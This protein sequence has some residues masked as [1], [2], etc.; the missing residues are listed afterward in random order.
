MRLAHRQADGVAR[1]CEILSAIEEEVEPALEDVEI[2]V[3]VRMDVRRHEGADRER[4]VPGKA[5]LRS[6]L[7]HIDL[8]E[9]V[10]GD[11]LNALIGAGEAGDFGDHEY[12]LPL[13]LTRR[14]IFGVAVAV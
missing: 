2:F 9:D 10:P 4:R 6:A 14:A 8:A 3:L 12:S 13:L 7:R 1:G 11:A 5:V